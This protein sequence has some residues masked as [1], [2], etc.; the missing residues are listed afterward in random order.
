[1]KSRPEPEKQHQPHDDRDEQAR[2][3]ASAKP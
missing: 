2:P 3:P 1:M